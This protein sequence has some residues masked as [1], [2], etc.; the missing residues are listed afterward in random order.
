MD[1]RDNWLVTM[2]ARAAYMECRGD[3]K[4]PEGVEGEQKLT[5]F[6]VAA[7]L[8]YMVCSSPYPD[9]INFD[10]YIE[11]ALMDEY[12]LR[13][14]DDKV[15]YSGDFD[16]NANSINAI[17]Y[18]L[19][20]MIHNQRDSEL[21]NINYAFYKCIMHLENQAFNLDN[22]LRSQESKH[23]EDKKNHERNS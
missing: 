14:V 2:G 20:D 5:E 6:V 9:L 22:R 4:L 17:K 12:G 18:S 23:V 21:K 11:K 15:D 7:V 1:L 3:I 8:T 10:E 13:K 16:S 19:R